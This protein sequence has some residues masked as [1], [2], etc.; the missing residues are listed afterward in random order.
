M[1]VVTSSLSF[2]FVMNFPSK[3]SE[4]IMPEKIHVLDLSF[5]T[6]KLNKN[7]GGTAGNIVYNLALLG[8]KPIILAT[9]GKTLFLTKVF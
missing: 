1:I 4:H 9:A 5:L 3:F 6:D 7:F 2:D 8:E